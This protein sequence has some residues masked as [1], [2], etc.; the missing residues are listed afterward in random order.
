MRPPSR[1]AFR[2]L[3][4]AAFAA[5]AAVAA[6]ADRSLAQPAPAAGGAGWRV[7]ATCYEI[8]VRSFADSDGDGIGDLR[9]LERRLDYINDGTPRMSRDLGARCIWLM[10][11]AESPSYHGYDVS[12]YYRVEPDYGTNADF[13]RFVAAAHRRGIKVL[14]D[15][16]LNHAS[17][18]HPYFQAALRDTAS[19]YRAWFRFS[20]SKPEGKG[21]WGQEV[22]HKSPVR[23]EWYYGIFW[24]GMPD[25]NYETAAVREEAKKV[26]RFWLD[27]MGVDGFRL[28]AIPYLVEEG[29]VVRGAPQTHAFMRE[30]QAYVKSVRPDAFTVG[31]VW[32]STEEMLTYYPNELESHFAFEASDAILNAV[33]RGSAAGLFAPFLK[34]QT[35]VPAQHRWS[36]F[37]RN[38]DQTRTMTE[39]LKDTSATRG[40][41]SEKARLAA[42]LLLTLPGLPF[43]YYGEEIGITGDKPDERLR[44]P[45]QWR[46]APAGGFS[47]GKAWEA[48]QADSMTVTVAAQDAEPRSLL[49]LHRRLIHLR[50]ATPALGRGTLVP[51]DAGRTDVAAFLRQDGP[52][53]VVVLANLGSSPVTGLAIPQTDRSVWRYR[54]LTTGAAVAGRVSLAPFE[55]R[56]LERRR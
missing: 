24:S 41:V 33:R 53:A 44:T 1:P 22:W 13:K 37:L 14:V 4:A 12:N 52:R 49:N 45:M 55:F 8:F 54:D 19:P 48:L 40:H 18:E 43:V 16:V 29:S 32:D 39:L 28:D 38:H 36:P 5:F 2:T 27:S 56:I 17:S 3:L 31:E 47:T 21:P 15:M 10:P 26:A 9:G 6:V 34:L 25:L 20:K 11:V 46:A 35:A 42:A 23:D 30:W 7:G 50:A 51:L